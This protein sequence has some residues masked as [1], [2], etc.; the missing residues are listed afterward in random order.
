MPFRSDAEIH[1][2]DNN[3]RAWLQSA[4]VVHRGVPCSIQV[5][6]WTKTSRHC[7]GLLQLLSTSLRR[8]FKT[9][10]A[11]HSSLRHKHTAKMH[12][13]SIRAG[14]STVAAAATSYRQL[15]QGVGNRTWMENLRVR[16]NGNVLTTVIGPPAHLYSFDPTETNPEPVDIGSFSVA[17]LSGITEVSHDI[18]IIT[19]S[20]F[21]SATIE[22]P[23]LNTSKI[24][25]V[26]FNQG[27]PDSPTIDLISEPVLP[28]VTVFNGETNFNESIILAAAPYD[29]SVVALDINTG[30]YWTAFNLTEMASVNG[31]KVGADGFLYWTAPSVGVVR[32]PLSADMTLGAP[33]FLHNASYD[34]LAVSPNGF[35]P[36]ATNGTR[37][38]YMADWDVD[39]IQQLVLDEA[40]GN[41]TS[42]TI[43]AEGNNVTTWGKPTSCDF[44]RT[45]A[46]KN[47]IYCNTGGDQSATPDSGLGG[48]LFEI[49]L[50]W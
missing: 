19:G 43:V 32:A 49:T 44:G 10:G 42:A 6:E 30:A 39:G 48:Q 8:S 37:Y 27:G 25:K 38:L 13:K 12:A 36:A 31:I 24:W 35:G 17:G 34:D 18:F 4:A 5:Q 29:D 2:D 7:S 23:P 26:D 1:N 33:Q 50:S 46:Q 16:S 9:T 41:V 47:K 21:T 20:D 22:E 40:T 15:H 3:A 14:L 11:S 45:A 28:L